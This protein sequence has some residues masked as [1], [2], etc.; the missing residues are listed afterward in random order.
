M[1]MLAGSGWVLAVGVVCLVACAA[2][3]FDLATTDADA[4]PE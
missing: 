4:E 3:T 1:T 2:S